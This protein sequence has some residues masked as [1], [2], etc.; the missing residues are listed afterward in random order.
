MAINVIYFCI[1]IKNVFIADVL[2]SAAI[3][4]GKVFGKFTKWYL[5]AWLHYYSKIK[6]C[7]TRKQVATLKS[8]YDDLPFQPEVGIAAMLNLSSRFIDIFVSEMW[9]LHKL[10]R[11]SV[12]MLISQNQFMLDKIFG[13]KMNISQ[14]F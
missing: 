8:V 9:G 1:N 4:N 10:L 5:Y 12:I 14:L 3:E 7:K 11:T 2:Y 6:C 13:M